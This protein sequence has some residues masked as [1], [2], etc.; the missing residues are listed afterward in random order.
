ML[1]L[2]KLGYEYQ[3]DKKEYEAFSV[4]MWIVRGYRKRETAHA[5]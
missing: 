3:Q 5:M 4:T 1:T 2:P